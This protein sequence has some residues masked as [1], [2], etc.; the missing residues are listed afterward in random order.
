MLSRISCFLPG[1]IHLHR[2]CL[3]I[4]RK[5]AAGSSSSSFDGDRPAP[6][7]L[8]THLQKEFEELQKRAATPLA[9]KNTS[10]TIDAASISSAFADKKNTT[11][12]EGDVHPEMRRKPKPEFE[13]D[14]N[15]RTGEVGGPKNDPLGY[16]KEWTYGGRATDF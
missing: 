14:S 12:N 10:N 5:V 13:G 9:S 15:P 11:L 16:E 2:R 6:P 3:H 7:R 1:S 4:S 8:P